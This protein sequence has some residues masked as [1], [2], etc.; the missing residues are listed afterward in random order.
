MYEKVDCPGVKITPA[1]GLPPFS[2]IEE[3]LECS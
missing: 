2:L 1:Q 3:S